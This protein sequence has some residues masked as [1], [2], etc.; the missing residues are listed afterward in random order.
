MAQ[1]QRVREENR[2]NIRWRVKYEK[3][4]DDTH[5]E[6]FRRS[7]DDLKVGVDGKLSYIKRKNS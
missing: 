1:Q 7:S 5:F 3:E 2:G 6:P 4:G